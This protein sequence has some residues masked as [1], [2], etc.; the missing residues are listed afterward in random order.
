MNSRDDEFNALLNASSL[1]TDAAR[2]LRERTPQSTAKAI[3]TITHLRNT[4]V[5]G[6]GPVTEQAVTDILTALGSLTS[7]DAGLQRLR[8]VMDRLR[9]H[10][11]PEA[12]DALPEALEALSSLS[13]DDLDSTTSQQLRTALTVVTTRL[14]VQAA[15]VL[16]TVAETASVMRVSKQTVYRL[17]H[18][19][20]L[21]AVRTASGKS[22]RIPEA[23]VLEYVRE[24]FKQAPVNPR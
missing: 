11:G 1:G 12:I 17:V 19:G 24:L 4:V 22:F 21:P 7:D 10:E 15:P 13:W 2:R 8:D 5:H 14:A 23:A 6:T 16:L 20:H 9:V 3:R 18:G